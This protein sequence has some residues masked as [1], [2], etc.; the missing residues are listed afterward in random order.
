[1]IPSFKD[2]IEN[3]NL[4][5]EVMSSKTYKLDIENKTIRGFINDIDSVKQA[6]Y[7]ILSTERYEKLIY[8]FNYGVELNNL[9]GKDIE[10]VKGDIE[11]RIKEALMQDDRILDVQDVYIENEGEG[12]SIVIKFN[13]IT[14]FGDISIEQEVRY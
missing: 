13:V 8:S 9:I 1:M 5:S 11:R 7:K 12:D 4:E 3:D 10:Y 6:I 2:K 14:I